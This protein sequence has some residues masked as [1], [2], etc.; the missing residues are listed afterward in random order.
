MLYVPCRLSWFL[1]YLVITL[2]V[3]I[4]ITGIFYWMEL[5]MVSN[6]GIILLLMVLGALSYLALTMLF[7]ALFRSTKVAGFVFSI[8]VFLLALVYYA[9]QVRV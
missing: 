9:V 4:V 8:S 6:F 7:S 2:I 5:F 3:T 1:I